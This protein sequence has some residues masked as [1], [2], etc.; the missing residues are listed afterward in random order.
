MYRSLQ[1]RH[2]KSAKVESDEPVDALVY[3]VISENMTEAQA[4]SAI[5][6]LKDY[7]IDWNDLRVATVDEI[8]DVLGKDVTGSRNIATALTNSLR[9]V[10]EKYNTLS[11]LALKKLGKRPAKLVLEKLAGTTPFVIDYCMLTALNA[12]AVPLTPRMIEY[13]KTNQ[14]AHPEADYGQIEGFLT[15]QIPLKNAYDFYSLLRHDS[16]SKRKSRSTIKE[17]V[18]KK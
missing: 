9:S 5:K 6:N 8:V 18:K 13:L 11:L 3:A 2:A 1:R 16:E 7:F 12:H 10:F 15:R 14:L 17:S 4:Q